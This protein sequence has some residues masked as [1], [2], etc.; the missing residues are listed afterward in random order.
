MFSF[1]S[2]MQHINVLSN[3][4]P[5]I[6]L[7]PGDDERVG[8][9]SF[10]FAINSTFV[11]PSKPGFTGTEFYVQIFYEDVDNNCEYAGGIFAVGIS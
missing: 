4:T 8:A 3:R 9:E 5:A 1:K 10:I 7:D 2:A 11:R 6:Q